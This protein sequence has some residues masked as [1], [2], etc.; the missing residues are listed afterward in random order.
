MK[1]NQLI[2]LLAQDRTAP[3]SRAPRFVG[4]IAAALA[5]SAVAVLAV[6]GVRTDLGAAVIDPATIMKWL[7]PLALA[8]A[9]G[10]ASLTL[11]RPDARGAPSLW[12]AGAIAVLAVGTI[13]GEWITTPADM[14][15]TEMRGYSIPG[16]LISIIAIAILPFGV[17][18]YTLRA[19]ASVKP[20]LS[21]AAAGLATGSG[22]AVAYAFH[23]NED[24]PLFYLTWYGAAI[25]IVTATGWLAGRH[26]LRW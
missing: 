12:L 20:G 10:I 6:L 2:G 21:G 11:S 22:A 24:A 15:W 26:W 23:C 4:G 19:G 8:L 9:A 13:L 18:I 3:V 16:C 7:L 14:R 17:A 1:T 25:L 5:V